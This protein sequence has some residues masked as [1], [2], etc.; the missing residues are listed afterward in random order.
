[1]EDCTDGSV[2][3]CEIARNGYYGVSIAEC[4][5]IS[6]TRNLIEANDR[7]GVMLEYL[8]NGSENITVNDNI[9]HYNNGYGVEAYAVKNGKVEKNV[10]AGNG[11]RSEQQKVTGEKYIL[12]E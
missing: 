8:F 9:I 4:R 5:N 1:M 2:T 12:M 7:S 6:V 3:N 10:Y 11:K